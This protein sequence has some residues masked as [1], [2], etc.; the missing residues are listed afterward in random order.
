MRPWKEFAVGFN[1]GR[2]RTNSPRL[3]IARLDRTHLAPQLEAWSVE[4]GATPVAESDAFAR[5]YA[6]VFSHQLVEVGRPDRWTRSVLTGYST[7]PVSYTHLTLPTNRE[8]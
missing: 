8:V 3:P 2:W 6:R 4:A 7:D 1:P 5:G